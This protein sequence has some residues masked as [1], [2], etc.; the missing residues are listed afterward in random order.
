MA[1]RRSKKKPTT[2]VEKGRTLMAERSLDLRGECVLDGVKPRRGM[3]LVHRGRQ[4]CY[5]MVLR[6][7]KTGHVVTTG[8]FGTQP[9]L[10]GSMLNE[11]GY[12]Y[13]SERPTG[14]GWSYLVDCTWVDVPPAL[15]A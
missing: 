7:R 12:S 5:G 3:W 4:R 8:G 6:V 15:A 10:L 9:E 2:L 11:G 14:E 1:R 13:A